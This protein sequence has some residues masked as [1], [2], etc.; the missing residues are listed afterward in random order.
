[1][2]V[3]LKLSK[4]R[5]CNILPAEELQTTSHRE[6]VI[7][8][9]IHCQFADILWSMMGRWDGMP[10]QST[11]LDRHPHRRGFKI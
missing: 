3:V 2:L 10:F 7:L 11:Y 5:Q 8:K 1:M 9:R 4:L 6:R